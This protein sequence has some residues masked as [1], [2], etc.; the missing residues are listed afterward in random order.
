MLTLT[1]DLS[2]SFLVFFV[3]NKWNWS[4]IRGDSSH[5]SHQ[6]RVQSVNSDCSLCVY[7]S[8]SYNPLYHL[9][10][11]D[12][13]YN[14]N[15]IM[16]GTFVTFACFSGFFFLISVQC[17]SGILY[18]DFFFYVKK[19]SVWRFFLEISLTDFT[20]LSTLLYLFLLFN[21]STCSLW[22]FFNYKI[23]YSIFKNKK[24]IMV[25]IM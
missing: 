1:D 7:L 25:I 16:N 14:I 22:F 19:K 18:L 21:F 13:Q 15:I 9:L 12:N 4:I 24:N 23:Y 8:L 11:H 2:F 17:F 6:S 3:T 20:F 10:H 5:S